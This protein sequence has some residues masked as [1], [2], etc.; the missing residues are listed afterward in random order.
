VPPPISP[1]R[2]RLGRRLRELRAA[3]FPSGGALARHLRE[4]HPNSSWHQTRVS[5]LE[6]GEQRPTETDIAQWVQATGASADEHERLLEMLKAVWIAYATHRDAY[7]QHGGAA[8]DQASIYS[9]EVGTTRIASF[10]PSMVQGLLQ[11]AAYAR[12]LLSQPCGPLAFG[13]TEDEIEAMVAARIKR[14]EVLYEPGKQVEL[15]LGEAALHT[16]VGSVATLAG[17]LDR[18]VAVAGLDTV[19]LGVVPFTAVMPI[20]PLGGFTIHDEVVFIESLSGEQSLEDPDDVAV[21]MKAFDLLRDAAVSGQEA[22][23]LI[24]RVAAQLRG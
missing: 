20:F 17:Q 21:Y 9:R 24:Q 16:R 12:E 1:Q 2:A 19:E 5:K 14:Q 4:Q 10:Q 15:L 3:A 7:G 8:G 6:R 23:A 22:V 18:L 11:T 13:A